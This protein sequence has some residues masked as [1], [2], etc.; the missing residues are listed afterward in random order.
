MTIVCCLCQEPFITN[1]LVILETSFEYQL[2]GKVSSGLLIL[3]APIEISRSCFLLPCPVMRLS[4]KDRL[5]NSAEKKERYRG[6]IG[7][8][9]PL[10]VIT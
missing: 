9:V 3:N 5:A 2:F 1:T 10:K 8:A 4:Q 7:V 6:Y